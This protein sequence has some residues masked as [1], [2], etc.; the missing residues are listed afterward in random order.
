MDEEKIKLFGIDIIKLYNYNLDK[1]YNI[2]KNNTSYLDNIYIDEVKEIKFSYYKDII[3]LLKD[4]VLL[5]NGKKKLENIKLLGFMSG[6]SIFAFSN[7]N[8]ITCLTGEWETTKFINNNDYKY[9]KIIITPL[10]IVALTYEK[11]VRLFGTII[12]SVVDY[13]RYIDVEDI[14]YVEENDDIVVFKSNNVY[15]LL[16][17]YDYSN[18]KPDVMI[19]GSLNEDVTI[20]SR[21]DDVMEV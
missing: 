19:Y 13:N 4:G 9:R 17:G 1:A 12:D 6:I 15:S 20:L 10:V 7:D 14:G 18:N 2:V 5:F 16:V 11:K 3:I 8:I 21:D